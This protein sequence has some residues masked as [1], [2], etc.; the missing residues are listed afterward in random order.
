MSAPKTTKDDYGYNY[1]HDQ[2]RL[3][4][5]KQFPD[6]EVMTSENIPETA[7]VE[8][9]M[10]Q[11]IQKVAKL[12]FPTSSSYGYLDSAINVGKRHPDVVLMHAG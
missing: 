6:L 7:E 12:L 2:G 8:R 4:V 5:E 11:M 10:E 3:A 1:E 9:L